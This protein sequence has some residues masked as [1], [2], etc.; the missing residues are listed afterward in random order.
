MGKICPS[1]YEIST[2]CHR[3]FSFQRFISS[4]R[5]RKLE[6]SRQLQ[7]KI[8]MKNSYELISLLLIFLLLKDADSSPPELKCEYDTKISSHAFHEMNSKFAFA[9]RFISEGVI[10]QLGFMMFIGFST[11]TA[12]LVGDFSAPSVPSAS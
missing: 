12:F 11:K 2:N 8:L 3:S 7:I 6:I 4:I 10:T 5:C 1:G 9:S